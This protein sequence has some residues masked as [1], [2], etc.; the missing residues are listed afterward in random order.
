MIGNGVLLGS[1][2]SLA[3][4]LGLNRNCLGWDIS[5]AEKCLRVRIWWAIFIY[6]KWS[7][8]LSHLKSLA[9]CIRSSVAYGTPP[10]LRDTQHDVPI[11]D[12]MDIYAPHEDTYDP[13]AAAVFVG[14]IT[15]TKI[16]DVYLDHVFILKHGGDLHDRITN[17]DL[18]SRLTQWEDSLPGE[19][20][21]MILRGVGLDIPGSSNLRLA[22]LYIK[23]LG[24]KLELDN[25]KIGNTTPSNLRNRQA[26][27]RRAA[28][29]IVLLIQELDDRALGD[30]WLTLS[31]FILSSTVTFLLRCALESENGPAGLSDSISLKLAHDMVTALR[32]HRQRVGWDLGDICIAQYS[33]VLE[34]LSTTAAQSSDA[35]PDFQELWMSNMPSVDDLFPSLW[36]MFDAA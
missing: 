11:P 10:H 5:I 23:L 27:V 14:L 35:V 8:A 3:H 17:L 26:Q 28:E 29:D 36:D 32:S 7:V 22:Y 20:R 30:F 18:E 9:D 2:I 4:S 31:C 25:E 15:L 19:I 16:L 33:D 6:D 24:Q 13:G 34:K 1:A 12:P 21:R